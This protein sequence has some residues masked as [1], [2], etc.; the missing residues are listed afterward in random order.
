MFLI[1]KAISATAIF[2][3]FCLKIIPQKNIWVCGFW[4]G[5]KFSN[6]PKAFYYYLEGIGQDVY[7]MVKDRRL[8]EDL[9]RQKVNVLSF[10][11]FKTLLICLQAKYLV[12]SVS[13][14]DLSYLAYIN[15][16]SKILINTWHGNG[17]KSLEMK[18]SDY[19]KFNFIEAFLFKV[20]RFCL[21]SYIGRDVDYAVAGSDQTVE[22]MKKYFRLNSSDSVLVT[23]IPKNDLFLSKSED[24]FTVKYLE[25]TKFKDGEK[26]I[27]YAP[28]YRNYK[29]K[30]LEF[31]I[32]RE[33]NFNL[34]EFN[35][36]L[37]E[38]SLKMYISLHFKLLLKPNVYKKY[39][40][41]NIIIINNKEINNDNS[42]L[43][44]KSDILI[45]DYSSIFTDFLLTQKPIIF[46]PFDYKEYM[47]KDKGMHYDYNEVTPGP[48]AKN[49]QEVQ[50]YISEFL[51]NPNLYNEER[52]KVN[53]LFN[54][55]TDGRSCERL[56][57]EIIKRSKDDKF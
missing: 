39:E 40:T 26:I 4:M 25:K 52:K 8:Y 7:F 19:Y 45:T 16:R 42:Y 3:D 54:K 44:A 46:N 48:K 30:D 22:K 53:K 12:T 41:E 6:N 11:S 50:S 21:V 5:E 32:L 9:K 35:N 49:W 29:F 56:Y 2:I 51:K 10:Y 24:P 38:N 1:E 31:D 18:K 17:I 28:T 20:V 37:K 23:G 27:F 34:T 55:Y 15:S 33:N 43:L 36:F 14:T 57:K 47:T 13:Y